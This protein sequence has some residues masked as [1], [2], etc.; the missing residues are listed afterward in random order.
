MEGRRSDAS[1]QGA[2]NGLAEAGTAAQ[3][4][5]KQGDGV[6]VVQIGIRPPGG[7]LAAPPRVCL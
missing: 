6:H 3:A 5:A 2:A 7:T 1:M 4:G